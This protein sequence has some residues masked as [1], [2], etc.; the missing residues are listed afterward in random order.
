MWKCTA[1][2]LM[3]PTHLNVKISYSARILR[4]VSVL[5]GGLAALMYTDTFQT[6][7]IIAGAF[8]LT[9]FCKY[10]L[11][12]LFPIHTT[13]SSCFRPVSVPPRPEASLTG[14]RLTWV[15]NHLFRCSGVQRA[16]TAEPRNSPPSSDTTTVA[17]LQPY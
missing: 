1:T 11:S 17:P 9:G 3:N 6:F 16:D 5:P 10:N 7:V 12:Y 8:V 13:C 4:C 15:S 14:K 2:L